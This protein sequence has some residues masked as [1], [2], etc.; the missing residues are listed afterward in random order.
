MTGPVPRCICKPHHPSTKA[1]PAKA[2]AAKPRVLALLRGAGLQDATKDP[3]TAEP[4]KGQLGVFATH[5]EVLMTVFRRIAALAIAASTLSCQQDDRLPTGPRAEAPS[6]MIA[7]VGTWVTRAPMLTARHALGVGAING[8]LYAVGGASSGSIVSTVEAYD[9]ASGMWTFK[10]P[11]P[12]ARANLSVTAVNGVLYAVG[13]NYAQG[14]GATVQAYDPATNIWTPRAPMLTA[15]EGIGLTAINGILYAVGGGDNTGDLATLEAYDPGTDSWITKQPMLTARYG[16]GVG[17]VNGILYAAGGSAGGPVATVEAYDPATNVWTTKA[18]MHT[19]RS[20]LAASVVNGRL[21]A[22]GGYTTTPNFTPLATVEA[23]DPSTD[24]WTTKAPMPTARLSL[25]ADVVNGLLYAVGGS[26]NGGDLPTVEAFTPFTGF[27]Q[28]VDNSDTVNVA[29]A[30]SAIPMK[31]SMGSNLG[32]DIL[33]PGSPSSAP[34]N[35]GSGPTDAIEETIAAT[36]SGL[37]YDATADQYTYVW[38]SEKGWSGTCRKFSLRLTD[39]ST[40]VALFQ[41]K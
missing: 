26:D 8:K 31:F 39:G 5:L 11:L 23:Y 33:S 18:P 41:F 34:F 24:M 6:F 15:R 22:V 40:H 21:Y 16:V 17:V 1:H 20:E 7:A 38:K 29:T 3:T 36:N 9:V 27:F 10:K 30:G 19:A 4:P 35:C 13:G 25:G 2:G 32:L 14:G 12:A 37:Q 28:P